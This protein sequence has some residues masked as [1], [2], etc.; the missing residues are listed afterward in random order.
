MSAAYTVRPVRSEDI[1]GIQ[2]VAMETWNNTYGTIYAKE[3][4]SS[5]LEQAYS[6]KNLEAAV[7]RDENSVRKF[8]VVQILEEIVAYG[9]LTAT[10]NEQAE[11]TRIYVLPELQGRGIGKALLKELVNSD[12]TITKVFAWVEKENQIGVQFYKANGFNLAEEKE[13]TVVG[14]VLKLIKYVK[15]VR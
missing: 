4:I 13:E 12:I 3:F 2:R 10:I 6:Y 5:F 9:Q 7:I 8:M 11:L 14:Q 15:Q 1:I